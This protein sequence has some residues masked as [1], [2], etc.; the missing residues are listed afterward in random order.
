MPIRR[1]LVELYVIELLNETGDLGRGVGG[2]VS[3]ASPA[4]LYV[5]TRNIPSR[6]SPD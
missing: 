1:I 2:G 3:S 6:G 5:P 4:I